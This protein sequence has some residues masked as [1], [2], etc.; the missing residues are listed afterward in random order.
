MST[1]NNVIPR[2]DDLTIL[3]K[4][5]KK[6]ITPTCLIKSNLGACVHILFMVRNVHCDPLLRRE[7]KRTLLIF[8][9]MCPENHKGLRENCVNIMS[10]CCFIRLSRRSALARSAIQRKYLLS[11]RVAWVWAV[12]LTKWNLKQS[13]RILK[14]TRKLEE[15][16]SFS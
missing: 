3:K 1:I 11:Y 14:N 2:T 15:L 7:K 5:R 9:V 10:R 16:F 12:F 4:V 13:L 8:L 6:L